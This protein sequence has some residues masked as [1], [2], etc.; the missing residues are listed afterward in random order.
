MGPL[1]TLHD[2][3][4]AWRRSICR[5]YTFAWAGERKRGGGVVKQAK[6]AES[7]DWEEFWRWIEIALS[8]LERERES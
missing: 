7:I 2:H 6:D 8:Q 1:T 3:C 4:I 5:I